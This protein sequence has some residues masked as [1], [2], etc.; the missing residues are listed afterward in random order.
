MDPQ[1]R[2]LTNPK[3]YDQ[4]L[5]PKQ[6]LGELKAGSS[7]LGSETLGYV[8]SEIESVV[9]RGKPLTIRQVVSDSYALQDALD[10]NTHR[11]L[12]EFGIT[13]KLGADMLTSY[14]TTRANKLA[15][16]IKPGAGGVLEGAFGAR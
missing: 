8:R 16:G 1:Q 5:D 3:D 14:L 4:P 15:D 13:S 6:I 12:H 11:C 10:H 2:A 9:S 7:G